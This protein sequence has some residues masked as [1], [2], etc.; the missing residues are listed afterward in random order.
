MISV[1][2]PKL[3]CSTFIPILQMGEITGQY[4]REKD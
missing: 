2:A 1:N 3:K 4:V